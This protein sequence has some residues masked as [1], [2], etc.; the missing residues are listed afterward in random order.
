MRVLEWREAARADLLHI[1]SYIAEDNPDAAQRVLDEIRE[2]AARL[3]EYPRLYRPGRV[4][5]T[6]EMVCG[7][8]VV[9]YAESPAAVTILRVLHGR[10]E[11]PA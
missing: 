5:G 3:P 2:K 7:S 1:V 8:Y 9:I 10:Q 6:R 4:E 11:W